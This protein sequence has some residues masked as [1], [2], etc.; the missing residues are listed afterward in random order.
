MM[1][2]IKFY[3]KDPNRVGDVMDI[4]IFIYLYPLAG[5]ES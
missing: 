2:E 4:L 5:L 1:L 3:T